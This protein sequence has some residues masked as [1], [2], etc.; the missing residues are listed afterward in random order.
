MPAKNHEAMVAILEAAACEP[1]G[2]VLMVSD[3]TKARAA[4][5]RARISE[6]NPRYDALQFRMWPYEDGN[7]VVCHQAPTPKPNNLGNID[8]GGI[9]D[10]DLDT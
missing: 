3:T 9:L 4:L 7:L 8:L 6:K 5:Y 10:L 1:I 2:I